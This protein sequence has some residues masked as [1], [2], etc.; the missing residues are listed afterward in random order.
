M[1]LFLESVFYP[2]QKKYT[3]F[4]GSNFFRILKISQKQDTTPLRTTEMSM[5]WTLKLKLFLAKYKQKNQPLQS[6]LSTF[7]HSSVFYIFAAYCCYRLDEENIQNFLLILIV[8]SQIFDLFK[9]RKNR[10]YQASA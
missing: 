6:A 8:L 9:V 2:G 1:A 10:D 5:H 4:L 7:S 3:V